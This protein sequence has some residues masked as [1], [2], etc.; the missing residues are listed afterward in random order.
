MKKINFLYLLFSLF[1]LAACGDSEDVDP[2]T[3]I[4][5]SLADLSRGEGMAIV[6]GDESVTIDAG[7]VGANINKSVNGKSYFMNR[8][9]I[10]DTGVGEP[11]TVLYFYIPTSEGRT[12][13]ADGTYSVTTGAASL[14]QTYVAVDVF[15]NDSYNSLDTTTGSV[16]ISNASTAN[17]SF[18]ATFTVGNLRSF[19]DNVVEV[20]GAFRY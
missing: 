16:V 19:D 8:V 15:A 10:G 14:D 3:P 2:D 1:I 12:I 18:D 11:K 13:P 5:V 17:N 9:T 6:S 4:T 7:I 20:S